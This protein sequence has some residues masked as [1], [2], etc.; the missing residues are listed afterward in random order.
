MLLTKI[1][2]ISKGQKQY[3]KRLLDNMLSH[4]SNNV[5]KICDFIIA[6]RNE[7]NI[8]EST[9]EWHIKVLDQ[10]LKFHD[11]KDLVKIT[12]DVLNCFVT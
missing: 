3:I 8:K 11:F 7:I 1:N 10:L 5:E 9:V 2:Q 4:S 12:K 6:E